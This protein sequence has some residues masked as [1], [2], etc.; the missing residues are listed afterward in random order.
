MSAATPV[1]QTLLPF[2]P[3]Q[4]SDG[5]WYRGSGDETSTAV[6]FSNT[7]DTPKGSKVMVSGQNS[8]IC[9]ANSQAE[10]LMVKILTAVAVVTTRHMAVPPPPTLT[11][12]QSLAADRF[13][14]SI[15][16]G[17]LVSHVQL[18]LQNC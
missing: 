8:K 15:I 5:A 18:V 17:Q 11:H 2:N 13:E 3:L 4:F 6:S 7:R 1:Y 9:A 14:F 10:N 12:V 16:T